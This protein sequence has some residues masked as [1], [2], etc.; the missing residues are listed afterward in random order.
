MKLKSKEYL[1]EKDYGVWATR[2]NNLFSELNQAPFEMAIT[3][4]SY[5]ETIKKHNHD[6]SEVFIL[7][8]GSGLNAFI[9]DQTLVMNNG[10][11]IYTDPHEFHEFTNNE[12]EEC[13]LFSIWW[14]K[15]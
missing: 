2:I 13:I 11:M 10:D 4:I 5:G 8:Q 12:K 15:T 7:F 14:K 3:K 1:F 9:N 6:E